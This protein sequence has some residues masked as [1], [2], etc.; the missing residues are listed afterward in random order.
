MATY[1]Q[2]PV[3]SLLHPRSTVDTT[4]TEPLPL[5]MPRIR[6]S[7]PETASI[8]SEAPSYRSQLA[9]PYSPASPVPLI[10]ADGQQTT[11][12]PY[13]RYAP[14]FQSRAHGSVGDVNAHN[15]NVANWST[16][17]SGPTRRQYENVA[18]RRAQRDTNVTEILNTLAAIPA[19]VVEPA[20][21]TTPTPAPT[22]SPSSTS[23]E[24]TNHTDESTPYSPAE[25]PAL[26]GEAAAAAAR[27]HRLYRKNCMLDQ[28]EALR[29]ESKSWD[30]MLMQMKDWEER[31]QSW[32]NFQRDNEGGRRGKLAK[33]IGVGRRAA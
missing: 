33:R 7:D 30:F 32:N 12:L 20:S 10:T 6:N 23:T 21:P 15:Y 27:S 31:Q 26:V 5:Y 22:S 19:S 18:R 16:V 14:G 2:P 13:R 29:A 24:S 8:I 9:P 4:D 3:R 25:D 11:G 1:V 28:R 17:R